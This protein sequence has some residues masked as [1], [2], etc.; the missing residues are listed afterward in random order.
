MSTA[1]MS[2]TVLCWVCSVVRCVCVCAVRVVGYLPIT[3]PCR[4]G[5]G[6][7][8]GWWGVCC[9]GGWHGK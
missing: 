7:Y 9:G 2:R 3:P 8:H 6:G 5:G 1:V 4:G